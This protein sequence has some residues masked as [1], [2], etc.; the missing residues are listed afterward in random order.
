MMYIQHSISTQQDIYFLVI[1]AVKVSL[2]SM[3]RI[4]DIDLISNC[5][6]D[7]VTYVLFILQNALA[8][9]RKQKS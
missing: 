7:V 8:C 9:C 6:T 1:P 5:L 4:L 3:Y 2:L